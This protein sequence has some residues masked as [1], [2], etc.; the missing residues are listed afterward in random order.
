[1]D[2][3]FYRLVWGFGVDYSTWL[4]SSTEVL[5]PVHYGE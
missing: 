3:W 4:Y 1:M 2:D 5:V